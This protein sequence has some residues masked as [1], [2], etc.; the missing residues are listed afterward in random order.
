MWKN[1]QIFKEFVDNIEKK[2]LGTLE[3]CVTRLILDFENNE[4][5]GNKITEF[6]PKDKETKR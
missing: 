1:Y 3:L 4:D 5:T 6:G 2:A